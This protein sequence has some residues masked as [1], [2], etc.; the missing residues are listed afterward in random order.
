MEK[1]RQRQ[2]EEVI[3]DTERQR[4]RAWKQERRESAE[5][6]ILKSG[7]RPLRL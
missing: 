5:K 4:A 2:K 1:Q 3:K 7:T 6:G